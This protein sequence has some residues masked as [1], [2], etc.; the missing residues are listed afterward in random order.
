V[1]RTGPA[2]GSGPSAEPRDRD[3]AAEGATLSRRASLVARLAVT[4][5][6][7][8]ASAFPAIIVYAQEL[9]PGRVG[10]VGASEPDQAGPTTTDGGGG[11]DRGSGDW[12]ALQDQMEDL[13]VGR[14]WVEGQAGGPVVFRCLVPVVGDRVVSQHF[15]AEGDDLVSASRTALRRIALWRATEATPE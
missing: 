14:F 2:P 7:L 10:L 8:M 11:G 4:V 1:E 13:G 3:P 6:L 9:L 15:E 5:G 12:T